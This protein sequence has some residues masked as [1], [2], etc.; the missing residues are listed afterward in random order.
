[1]VPKQVVCYQ[2]N[3]YATKT[4]GILPKQTG[5][6]PKQIGMLQNN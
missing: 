4:T 6:L 5:M 2:N 3:W 1:M